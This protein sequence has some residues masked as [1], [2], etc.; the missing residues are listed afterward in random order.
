MEHKCVLLDTSFFIRLL[1]DS[2]IL[3]HNTLGYYRYFLENDYI[4]KTST[5]SIAEYCVKGDIDHLPLQ[6][7]QIVPFNIH[8]AE[9]AGKLAALVFENKNTLTL[10]DRRIIPNDTKLFA[11]ADTENQINKFVTSDAECI[12]IFNFLNQKKRLSFEIINIRQPYK[13]FFGELDFPS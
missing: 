4:L 9:K 10:P 5:I 2:D 8:H 13:E 12:K 11:Q 1:N 6:V 7:V 3:H